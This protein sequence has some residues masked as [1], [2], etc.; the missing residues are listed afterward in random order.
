MLYN[1]K[2]FAFRH[3][4]KLCILNLSAA[5]LYQNHLSNT[6]LSVRKQDQ[7]LS[8]T[9]AQ[10]TNFPYFKS[11]LLPLQ[12]NELLLLVSDNK[13]RLLAENS[14]HNMLILTEMSVWS[15]FHIGHA[16][17]TDQNGSLVS[18]SQSEPNIWTHS[19]HIL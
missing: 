11:F 18:K 19:Y 7:V 12:K 2:V 15:A 1:K 10:L 3:C 13:D 14:S 17:A 5:V 8:R 9:K 16:A 6:A 4:F